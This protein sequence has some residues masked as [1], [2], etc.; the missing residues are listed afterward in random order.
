M[1]L[2]HIVASW[3]QDDLNLYIAKLSN[4][5]SLICL[6]PPKVLK[7]FN[8]RVSGLLKNKSPL[9]RINACKLISIVVKNSPT[10]VHSHGSEWASFLMEMLETP[11]A[12][13][14]I[15]A[16]IALSHIFAATFG[17]QELTRDITTPRLPIYMKYVLNLGQ[18]TTDLNT[19]VLCIKIINGILERQ[20]TS[21]RPIS[22]NYGN[23]LHAI[24]AGI[25]NSDENKRV[26]SCVFKGIVLLHMTAPK[27]EAPDQ[28]RAGFVDVINSIHAIIS[29][30]AS[31]LV[32]ED[33]D[34]TMKPKSSFLA[35]FGSYRHVDGLFHLL[36]AY[37]TT[38]IKVSVKFPL[39]L[40]TSLSDRV[41]NLSSAMAVFRRSVPEYEQTILTNKMESI[42]VNVTKLN[43]LVIKTVG[44]L[45]L[46]HAEVLLHN[47]VAL[48]TTIT[49]RTLSE[50]L[51]KLTC[52]LL[53]L[54]STVPASYA[55]D[56]RKLIEA[57]LNLMRPIDFSTTDTALA[58]YMSNPS[59]FIRPISKSLEQTICVFLTAVVE[60]CIPLPAVVR[61]DIDRF[62]L[63]HGD[64]ASS[65]IFAS[66]HSILP[67]AINQQ[68]CNGP[69]MSI[70]HPR[71]PP[72]LSTSKD[73]VKLDFNER[74]V[75]RDS[76][77]AESET[78]INN[79]AEQDH[80][81]DEEVEVEARPTTLTSETLEKYTKHMSNDIGI[82]QTV[83]MEQKITRQVQQS[84][85]QQQE[86]EEIPSDEEIPIVVGL[87]DDS[88]MED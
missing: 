59:A 6:A 3:T 46:P 4:S 58:D 73:P 44:T 70:I 22:N 13:A 28:W 87:D 50:L 61:A 27:N 78:A 84:E 47:I 79:A 74:I 76:S 31:D 34:F 85:Q 77:S 11:D 35:Q 86:M 62:L 55:T 24:V 75:Y 63:L 41:Y 38:P 10:S 23:F 20:A 60:T 7:S 18:S 66:K 88:D 19:Q 53:S 1:D 12:G 26:P 8:T 42:Q 16:I 17:K 15:S 36:R 57:A 72:L 33:Q 65:A 37:V 40:L 52:Q 2:S 56:L 67:M 29:S 69:L 43:M 45:F 80:D 83:V 5:P 39:G 64:P 68:T 21:V 49:N 14:H 30:L 54:L 81:M 51:L 48:T 9:L 25:L 82:S 71:L 32:E